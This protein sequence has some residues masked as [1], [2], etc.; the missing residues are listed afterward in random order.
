M[1]DSVDRPPGGRGPGSSALH[2]Q[3]YQQ[4]LATPVRW[5]VLSANNRD[6]GRGTKEFADEDACSQ[7]IAEFLASLD[8]LVVSLA[9]T[10]ENRWSFRLVDQDE[11]VATSGH[12]FDRRTRCAHAAAHFIDL[13]PTAEIRPGVALL[14]SS[15]WARA[16]VRA[17]P[18]GR[19]NVSPR[20]SP[21]G[22]GQPRQQSRSVVGSRAGRAP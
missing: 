7:G 17:D 2:F 1:A 10:P 8:G 6:M 16:G 22:S 19:P 15:S 14:T 4:G 9:R 21:V 13:V 18:V 12:A 20:W 11:I 3:L 5:R